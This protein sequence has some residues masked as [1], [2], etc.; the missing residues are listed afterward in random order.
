LLPIFRL[1]VTG[2]PAA[3]LPAGE[4]VELEHAARIVGTAAAP[5]TTAIPLR[6][7]R[8]ETLRKPV[9]DGVSGPDKS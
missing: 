1:P 8:R 7:F 6:T 4:A 2:P 3:A 9:A 5:T